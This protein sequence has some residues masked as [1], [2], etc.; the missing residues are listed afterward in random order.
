MKALG[1]EREREREQLGEREDS[2]DSKNKIV[3]LL[4]E[5]EEEG[6]EGLCV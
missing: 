2:L 1:Q 4:V 3:G 6:D 5:E